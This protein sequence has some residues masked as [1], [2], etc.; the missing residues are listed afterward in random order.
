MKKMIAWARGA[1]KEGI[2]VEVPHDFDQEDEQHI[3]HFLQAA[4]LS[5]NCSI[6][7]VGYCHPLD[8]DRFEAELALKSY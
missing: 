1:I 8:M 3:Q 7:Q 5:L 2:E 6:E 4:A